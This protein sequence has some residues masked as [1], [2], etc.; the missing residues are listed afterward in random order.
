MG[1]AF[2][3]PFTHMG[4][5]INAAN[6]ASAATQAEPSSTPY[7]LTQ[8]DMAK[9]EKGSLLPAS[10]VPEDIDVEGEWTARSDIDFGGHYDAEW[11]IT[12]DGD[13]IVITQLRG[14]CCWK[15]FPDTVFN[16]CGRPCH[17]KVSRQTLSKV[18][19][20]RWEGRFVCQT[21]VLTVV[22]KNELRHSVGF[23]EGSFTLTR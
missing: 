15:A 12:A 17:M 8:H 18:A 2:R 13:D 20:G 6:N 14:T 10:N 1:A 16:R 7:I 3:T 11:E 5:Y 9:T 4:N 19:P 23:P 22:S 21:L